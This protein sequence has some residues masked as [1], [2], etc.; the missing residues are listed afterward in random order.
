MRAT[1]QALAD[2]TKATDFGVRSNALGLDATDLYADDRK[3]LCMP[4]SCAF[5]AIVGITRGIKYSFALQS[6]SWLLRLWRFP[7]VV[8]VIR[9]KF[10][11]TSTS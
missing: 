1:A 8:C 3:S 5:L 2:G 7:N 9:G 6:Q 11:W 4:V 10:K